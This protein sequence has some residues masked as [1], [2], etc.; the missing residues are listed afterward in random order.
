MSILFCWESGN[1]K[2][3]RKEF[4][5]R[6]P[7]H[8][9]HVFPD[10]PSV[11]DVEYALVWM[12]PIGE[13]ARFPNLKAIFSIGAGCDHILRDPNVPRHVPIV[14][15][16]DAVSVRDMSHFALHWVL[17]FQRNFHVYSEQQRDGVWQRH[18]YRDVSENWVGVLGLG[19][20]GVPIAEQF[21]TCGFNVMGWS[22]TRKTVDGV[23]CFAGM[24]EL[25]ELLARANIVVS[26]LPLTD[27][28]DGLLNR[29][30]FAQ[31]RPGSFVIN[32][33]RGPVINDADLVAALDSGRVAA[34][35]LDVFAVEPLPPEHAFWNHPRVFI[36]PHAAGP[37]NDMSAIAQIVENIKRLERGEAAAPVW[38]WERGY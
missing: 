19:G 18:P 4:A 30:R 35:A 32:I 33:G 22:S 5:D 21:R 23:T 29:H 15:L 31:M 11:D 37:T 2:L 7:R 3:W 28:T 12:P 17:H 25:G 1:G 13:L 10:V 20:M 38:N 16:V 8:D 24:D 27:V 26:V 36:T 14:R 9:F 34:A 6:L